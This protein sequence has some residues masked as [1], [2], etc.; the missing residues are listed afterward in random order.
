METAYVSKNKLIEL[1]LFD[2]MF[3]VDV[4]TCNLS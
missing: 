2:V 4:V 3:L 1:V